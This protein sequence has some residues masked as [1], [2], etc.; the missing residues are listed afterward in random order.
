MTPVGLSPS[1]SSMAKSCCIG[2][3]LGVVLIGRL[4]RGES[5]PAT[6]HSGLTAPQT[7]LERRAFLVLVL[8]PERA[9]GHVGP[10]AGRVVG[11]VAQ[12]MG[13]GQHDVRLDE[14]PG[15]FDDRARVLVGRVGDRQQADPFQ[16]RQAR[17]AGGRLGRRGVGDHLRQMDPAVVPR[18]RAAAS[19]RTAAR[20]APTLATNASAATAKPNARMRTP[21]AVAPDRPLQA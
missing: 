15:A 2:D 16:R 13:G 9:L 19:T 12:T 6:V 20:V 18:A 14:L 1:V 7:D 3:E 11:E 5:C 17:I 8:Q 21:P 10:W 4:H